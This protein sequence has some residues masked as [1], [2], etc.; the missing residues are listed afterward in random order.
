MTISLAIESRDAARQNSSARRLP[1]G[2]HDNIIAPSTLRVGEYNVR[3]VTPNSESNV[4]GSPAIA[5]AAGTR[6]TA[7]I[8]G[9]LY[10]LV[11]AGGLF[12]GIVDESVTVHGDTAATAAAIAAH[13]SLWR[14]GIAVHLIYLAGPATVMNVLLYGII[15]QVQ[16][17]LALIALTSGIVSQA[18]EAAAL[19][20]L[21]VPLLTIEFPSA[22][23]GIGGADR[24]ALLYVALRL[25]QIGFGL[26][27]F[28]FS[29]FC[30]ALGTAIL[31]TALVPKTIGVMMIIAGICYF[32]STL[33]DAIAPSLAHLLSPW[34]IIPCFFGEAS[35]AMWLLVKGTHSSNP[36][37]RQ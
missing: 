10:V 35:L 2:N 3:S 31:R 21:Y 27:L 32:I 5:E 30:A 34:I 12:A 16:P 37:G 28:F 29:G 6:R 19:L 25:S 8:A 7:R 15:K 17:T 24:Q 20:P 11:I 9:A 1:D 23:A 13:E 33:S 4:P 26:A 36:S 14:W 18:V 22:L